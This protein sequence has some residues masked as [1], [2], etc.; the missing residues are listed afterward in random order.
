MAKI[1]SLKKPTL[2]TKAVMAF[3]EG[4]KSGP[5]AVA[6]SP[7]ASSADN[8]PAGLKSGMIPSGDVRL[9]ANIQADLH[10]KLK[11]RAAQER[12]TVG[13]LIESWVASW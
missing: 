7:V 5:K 3:A 10:L 9:T 11:I 4:G 13:E 1:A 6:G 2:S 8:A 12:T